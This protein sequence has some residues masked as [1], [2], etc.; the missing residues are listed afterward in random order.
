MQDNTPQ[1]A[2]DHSDYAGFWV[3]FFS[4]CIDMLIF[5]P[6]YV[7]LKMLPG[8]DYPWA[9][10][11]LSV[12]IACVYYA[13][14]FCSKMKGTPGMYI[15]GFHICNANGNKVT[16]G[17]ALYWLIT[18]TIGWAF[19]FAGV[20]YLQSRFDLKAVGDLQTSCIE[21]NISMDDCAKEI[22]TITNIPFPDLQ[23][24]CIA[25]LILAAFMSL[26]WALSIALPKDKTGFHNLLCGT[27]FV[28]GRG[29]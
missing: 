5:T 22:E 6:V 27:R 25:A 10:E 9:K 1:S 15:L 8:L 4:V 24:L 21:Q 28:K 26:I 18:S 23:Q 13:A 3:R 29:V 11:G 16:A 12:L 7:G 20:I 17:Q 14:F 2:F 19:C